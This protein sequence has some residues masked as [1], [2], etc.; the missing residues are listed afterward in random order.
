MRAR[1]HHQRGR[2]KNSNRRY[3]G[4]GY[5]HDFVA[6]ERSDVENRPRGY[7]AQRDAVDELLS[8]EPRVFLNDDVLDHRDEDEAAAEEQHAH[9]GESGE[10][11]HRQG[12][13]ERKERRRR[14]RDA[15]REQ[16]G[17]LPAPGGGARR[18]SG[19]LCAAHGGKNEEG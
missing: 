15:K 2:K 7:L 10:Q 6:D 13:V 12:G 1:E 4:A 9:P 14:Q 5:P 19:S 8:R 18:A 17:S 16:L 3:G 11:L